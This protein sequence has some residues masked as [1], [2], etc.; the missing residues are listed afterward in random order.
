MRRRVKKGGGSHIIMPKNRPKWTMGR[1][2]TL[3]YKKKQQK[4]C[5]HERQL[6]EDI[7]R[8]EKMFDSRAGIEGVVV[9]VDREE[10]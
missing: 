9:I 8:M 6:W 1:I 10:K 7:R 5:H 4:S 3:E 2:A